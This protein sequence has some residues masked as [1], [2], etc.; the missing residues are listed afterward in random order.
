MN[1][2]DTCED[3]PDK[4]PSNVPYV[5]DRL[6]VRITLQFTWNDTTIIRCIS[7]FNKSIIINYLVCTKG[8]QCL[9][10]WVVI[11]PFSCAKW[12]LSSMANS[13]LF[14]IKTFIYLFI[15][16][17]TFWA[18]SCKVFFGPYTICFVGYIKC[19]LTPSST[20]CHVLSIYVVLM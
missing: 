8:I 10:K 15:F 1:W 4:D 11:T 13:F 6:H 14:I 18:P 20:L 9:M 12:A 3:I 7:I 5:Q 16:K 17:T 19:T 2:P